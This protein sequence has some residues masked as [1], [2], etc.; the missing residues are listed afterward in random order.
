M[1][2]ETSIFGSSFFGG[3]Q[4]TR[5][6]G[7]KVAA[8]ERGTFSA[9]SSK[10][11]ELEAGAHIDQVTY[12]HSFVDWSEFNHQSFEVNGQQ[13]VQVTTPSGKFTAPKDL[14]RVSR[15]DIKYTNAQG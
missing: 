7:N 15:I 14:Y 12:W 11:L 5:K 8:S 6:L 9:T 2:S 1:T 3:V 10:T 4:L 13:F